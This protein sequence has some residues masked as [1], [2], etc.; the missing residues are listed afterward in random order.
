LLR[1]SAIT[2]EGIAELRRAIIAR[3]GLADDAEAGSAVILTERQRAAAAAAA[4][5]FDAAVSALAAH[6][7]LEVVALEARAGAAA[8]ATL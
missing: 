2:G 4:V 1:S 3:L 8:L 5:A 6:A 7:A